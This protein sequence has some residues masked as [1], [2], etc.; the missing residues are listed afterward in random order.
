MNTNTIGPEAMKIVNAIKSE[1]TMLTP[2]TAQYWIDHM[3]ERQRRANPREVLQI[4]K[5]IKNGKFICH[6]NDA[7]LISTSGKMMNAQHRCL[8]AIMTGTA[9]PIEIKYNVPEECFNWLDQGRARNVSDFLDVKHYKEVAG[10]G[11]FAICLE[12]GAGLSGAI[13]GRIKNVGPNGISDRPTNQ[14]ILDYISEN[15]ELLEAVAGVAV[16]MYHKAK[17][18]S[19]KILASAIWTA[20]TYNED[21]D[22]DVMLLMLDDY[23]QPLPNSDAMRW[24]DDKMVREYATARAKGLRMLSLT[25]FTYYLA[26]IEAFVYEPEILRS[27]KAFLKRV[28][29]KYNG[30]IAEKKREGTGQ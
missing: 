11:R 23:R 4:A 15:R 8:A 1:F 22:M 17:V 18:G 19:K 3:D 30:L 2:E 26:L 24:I 14:D 28:E 5:D 12:S 21:I 9:I 27:H 7:M 6:P 16:S 20:I 25:K 13:A 10:L 29:K